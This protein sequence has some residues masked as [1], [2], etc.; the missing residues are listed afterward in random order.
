MTIQYK[1][2]NFRIR[3]Q[4]VKIAV[5]AMTMFVLSSIQ[6]QIQVQIVATS[7]NIRWDTTLLRVV[8]KFSRLDYDF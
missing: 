4:K 7:N 8:K 6:D 3:I 2:V 1:V 5:Y